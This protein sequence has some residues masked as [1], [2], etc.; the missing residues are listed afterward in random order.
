MATS[1]LDPSES[2]GGDAGSAP[3]GDAAAGTDLSTTSPFTTEPDADPDVDRWLA[4]RVVGGDADA[5]E[6]LLRRHRDRIYR[7]A[8]RMLGNPADADDV[9]QDV[10]IQL[11]TGL[12]SFAG[13]A[14]FTTWL[15]RVVVNRCLNFR[16]RRPLEPLTEEA[17]PAA[18]GPETR[19]VAGQE[20]AAGLTVLARMPEHLRLTLVLVQLEGLSYAEAG[21][22]LKVSEATVRGRLARA[23]ALLVKQMRSWT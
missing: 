20:L 18:P 3:P 5:Y 8:L 16:R 17:H 2:A 7:I 23:R 13:S 6:E 22:V 9:T 21:A 15:Y 10:A 1:T 14:A 11:W 4:G 19:V 12:S